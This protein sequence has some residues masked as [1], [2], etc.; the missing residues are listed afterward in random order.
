MKT[1]E[2]GRG[3]DG[4]ATATANSGIHDHW[5]G[6]LS[7]F[8]F[9]IMQGNLSRCPFAIMQAEASPKP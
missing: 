4:N 2:T 3:F 6:N 8:P 1:D 7:R 5:Q 9:V